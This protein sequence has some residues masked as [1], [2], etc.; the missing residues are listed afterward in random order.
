MV[1]APAPL[2]PAAIAEYL[3]RYP[4]AICREEF[5]AAIYAL[6]DQ[7][8]RQWDEQQEK[9]QAEADRKARPKNR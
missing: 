3:D 7:F 4:S 5:D 8:R 1:G 2:A 6:D 9:D